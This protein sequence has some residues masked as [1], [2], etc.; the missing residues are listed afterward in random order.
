M[1]ARIKVLD[2]VYLSIDIVDKMMPKVHK[3]VIKGEVRDNE[4]KSGKVQYDGKNFI[5]KT[6]KRTKDTVQIE[7]WR[8]GKWVIGSDVVYDYGV[9]YD[10]I[11]DDQG[12]PVPPFSVVRLRSNS[13]IERIKPHL[14]ALQED[15]FIIQNLKASMTGY[16]VVIDMDAISNLKMGDKKFSENKVL[17]MYKLGG[18][19]FYSN[20]KSGI[21]GQ[22][23]HSNGSPIHELE[24]G[25][26]RAFNEI[27]ND[28]VY[29]I[30]QIQLNT[31]LNDVALAQNPNPEV[32]AAQANMA[33]EGSK[34]AI[35]NIYKAYKKIKRDVAYKI[36]LHLQ[37]EARRGSTYYKDMV[38]DE[39]FEELKSKKNKI[40]NKEIKIIDSPSVAEKNALMQQMNMSLQQQ[41]LKPS[42]IFEITS[43]LEE[44]KPLKVIAMVMRYKEE[45]AAKEQAENAQ[46]A[47]QANDAKQQQMVETKLQYEQAK[48]QM[49]IQG[50]AQI[51]S[52][53]FE[54]E[55]ILN[56][57]EI[58]GKRLI[59]EENDIREHRLYGERTRDD[60]R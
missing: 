39:Y 32:T 35:M 33:N 37:N 15:A 36:A 28:M 11:R 31:G 17:K 2:F 56:K 14:D 13:I 50:E 29:H 26:G 4:V 30:Q 47:Q 42:D 41:L 44:G 38:G 24:G 43:M 1:P 60:N 9:V 49:K 10:Q 59:A 55:R 7:T 34:N 45:K 20:K 57:E 51:S 12:V 25:M 19:L 3:K 6:K 53:E 46:A 21:P 8:R 27:N 16:S 23:G 5:K 40:A 54:Q 18:V 58:D 48:E 22:Q 52:Q